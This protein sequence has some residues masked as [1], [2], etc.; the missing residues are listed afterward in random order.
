MLSDGSL[1]GEPSI[2]VKGRSGEARGGDLQSC[3]IRSVRDELLYFLDVRPVHTSESSHQRGDA[4]SFTTSAAT[5][6]A[7]AP[8]EKLKDLGTFTDLLELVKRATSG[9]CSPLTKPHHIRGHPPAPSGAHPAQ[10]LSPT[11]LPTAQVTRICCS[12]T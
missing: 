10:R 3:S 8:K 12:S 5:Q 4:Q 11:P 2:G 1:R 6:A 9:E 7:M